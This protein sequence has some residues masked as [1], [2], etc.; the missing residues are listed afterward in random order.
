MADPTTI[1]GRMVMVMEHY[2][3]NYNSLSIRMGL[4]NT[5]IMAK[6]LKDSNRKPSYPTIVKFMQAFPKVNCAWLMLGYG[7]MFG[8][9]DEYLPETEDRIVYL[10]NKY[11]L[12]AREFANKI[13]I[14][15]NEVTGVL[16]KTEKPSVKMLS[17]IASEFP[18]VSPNW[19]FLNEGRFYRKSEG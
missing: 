13:S 9:K 8:E 5:T 1:N 18:D 10:L 6:N 12:S 7:H 2:N 14:P 11:Q 17:S 19:L 16:S 4:E 3:L 15:I